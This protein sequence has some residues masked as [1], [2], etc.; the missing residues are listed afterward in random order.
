[1]S[2]RPTAWE[3]KLYSRDTRIDS[4]RVR[5]DDAVSGIGMEKVIEDFSS[6]VFYTS[7]FIPWGF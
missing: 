2:D 5:L 1:M 7:V 4:A 6:P 3:D